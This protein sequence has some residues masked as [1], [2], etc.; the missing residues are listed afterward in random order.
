MENI[1]VRE[2]PFVLRLDGRAVGW[3]REVA[4]LE[5]LGILDTGASLA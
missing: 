2:Y 5:I 1:S 3:F 4:G